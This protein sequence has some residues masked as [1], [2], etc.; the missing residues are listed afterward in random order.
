MAERS[1]L[2]TMRG[3]PLTLVGDEIKVGDMAPDFEALDEKLQPMKL[4]TFKGKV[5]VLSTVMSLDTQICDLETKEFSRELKGLNPDIEFLTIS[6]D[7]PFA[8]RRWA[9]E[10]GVDNVRLLSDHREASFGQKYGV[11]IKNMRL[12]ARTVFVID[13]EGRVQYIQYVKDAAAEPDYYEVLDE[14]RKFL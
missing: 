12:L 11:L 4:S 7:L 3:K 10:A 14:V 13:K 8:Q 9:T 2:T 1:D 6:M 5:V